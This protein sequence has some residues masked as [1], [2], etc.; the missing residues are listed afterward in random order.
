[1]IPYKALDLHVCAA[2]EYILHAFRI[3]SAVDGHSSVARSLSITPRQIN[4][5]VFHCVS[6]K[7]W[8]WAQIQTMRV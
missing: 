2:V 8:R 6:D 3:D 4:L 5:I 1:M 7:G